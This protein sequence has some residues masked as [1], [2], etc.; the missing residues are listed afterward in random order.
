MIVHDCVQGSDEWKKLRAGVP[1]ASEFSRIITS[2]GEQSKSRFGYACDLAAEK[3][4]G[5]P[6]DDSWA[7]NAWTE[8]GKE[9]E[10]E[11]RARYEFQNDV[12][13]QQI[14]FCTSDDGV[15]GCSPDGLVGDEGMIETKV[16]KSQHHVTAILRFKKDGSIDP[17]YIQQTQGQLWVTG[18][19][20]VDL[21]FYSPLL[22]MLVVRQEPLKAVFN[23]LI[24]NTAALI[25]ER[26]QVLK[27]LRAA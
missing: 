25:I 22:P 3:F 17:G 27:V 21:V 2:T 18:R 14:G 24:S 4:A 8:R 20:W 7:G 10:A 26:E 12:A 11:A 9:V 13:I 19:K 16:L 1:T 5:G 6:M 23:G 15:A